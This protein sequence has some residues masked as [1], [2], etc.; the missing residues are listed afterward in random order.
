MKQETQF[1]PGT[2]AHHKELLGILTDVEHDSKRLEAS[3]NIQ[4]SEIGFSIQ[5][6]AL[7]CRNILERLGEPASI[8]ESK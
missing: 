7:V 2:P 8:G 3:Q 1:A 4:T 6:L 5:R